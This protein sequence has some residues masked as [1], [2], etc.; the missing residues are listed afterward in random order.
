[1]LSRASR[2]ACIASRWSGR[3]SEKPH[4]RW[5]ASRNKASAA[6][7]PPVAPKLDAPA[8]GGGPVSP[9]LDEASPSDGGS[10]SGVGMLDVVINETLEFRRELVV[11]AAQRLDVLAV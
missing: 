4:T 11:G 6:G 10:A 1:M 2:M 5:R 3:N 9:K 8:P 7:A